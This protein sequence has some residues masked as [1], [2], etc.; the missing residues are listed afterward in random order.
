MNPCFRFVGLLL[1]TLGLLATPTI[2]EA[3]G[4]RTTHS[5][6]SSTS[7]AGTSRSVHVRSYVRRDGTPVSAHTRGAP[8]IRRAGATHATTPR[9]RTTARPASHGKSRGAT[10]GHTAK[11]RLARSETAKRAFE[12]QTGYPHG[13][14]GYVVDHIRP[15]ACGGADAPSN[16][17]WQTVADAKAK[18]KV[19][20]IG[21]R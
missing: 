12:S 11:G 3:R 16:M 4:T 6:R 1:L 17:Q 13:R 21:C 7:R 8:R 10:V 20:R 14:P 5:P 18:D 2:S 15:L 19:E 9:V